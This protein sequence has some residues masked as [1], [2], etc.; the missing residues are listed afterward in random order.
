MEF[1]LFLSSGS[2][3]D[4][5]FKY[6]GNVELPMRFALPHLS[7]FSLTIKQPNIEDIANF[8]K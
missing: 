8:H 1:D 7:E 5:I 4:D 6:Q 2:D 3:E